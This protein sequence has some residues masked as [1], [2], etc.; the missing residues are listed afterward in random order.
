MLNIISTSSEQQLVDCDLIDGG[1]T[2]GGWH[3]MA[4]KY[5]KLTSGI[6]RQSL[7]PYTATVFLGNNNI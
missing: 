5:I 4:W 7:Y 6:T 3:T 2:K 1:C